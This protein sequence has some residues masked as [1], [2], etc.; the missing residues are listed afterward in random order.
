MNSYVA[1]GSRFIRLRHIVPVLAAGCLM[2]AWSLACNVPV[3]R[4]ALERW[5]ADAYRVTVFHRGPLSP[6]QQELLAPLDAQDVTVSRNTHVRLV[7][8]SQTVAPADQA[9]LDS[10][11]AAEFPWV[12]VRYPEYLRI[13]AP[14]WSGPLQ[15][16]PIATLLDSPI[17]KELVRRLTEG[18]T[19]VWLLLE[20]GSP[21]QDDEA[22]AIIEA[23]LKKL[24]ELLTLPELTDD[25]DDNLLTTI[26][27]KVEFSLLRIPRGDAREEALVGML[28]RSEPD[29][30]E[31]ADPMVFPVFG[32][33]RA[34][35]P[36][37]GPGITA[38][39]ILESA[40][41]LVG[42]CSCE[43]K[44]L[45]PGFDLLL[46]AAWEDLIYDGEIPPQ[47]LATETALVTTEPVLVPIPRGSSR[48]DAEAA[49]VSM[50]SA[51]GEHGVQA[52]SDSRPVASAEVTPDHHSASGGGGSS[53]AVVWVLVGMMAVTMVVMGYVYP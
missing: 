49:E 50:G 28:I 11:P 29:L 51:T 20:S 47:A 36:L 21:Q 1:Y 43:I 7:D 15:A 33:G 39:N 4:F 5:R 6:A 48:A 31:R 8:L 23:Q 12:V 26:P 2:A 9:L 18:Q 30:I 44:D 27:L 19:A 52:A 10:H 37:I 41:F 42:P 17:R 40:S 32:R 53:S 14:V 24:A 34:L 13:E 45:N 35:L 22:A 25:P 16:E 3:F 46:S 38:R